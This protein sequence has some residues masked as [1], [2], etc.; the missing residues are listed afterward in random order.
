MVPLGWTVRAADR[1]ALATTARNGVRRPA[2]KPASPRHRQASGHRNRDHHHDSE[3]PICDAAPHATAQ[4]R[5]LLPSAAT[6]TSQKGR[7]PS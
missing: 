3:A 5:A 2:T 1:A 4:T 7:H 6:S